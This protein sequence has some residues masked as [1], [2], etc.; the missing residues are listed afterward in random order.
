MAGFDCKNLY[1]FAFAPV[2][3]QTDPI[4]AVKTLM[5]KVMFVDLCSE[6]IMTHQKCEGNVW[7]VRQKFCC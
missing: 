6:G 5:D 3:S 2:C 4:P 7:M 1:V